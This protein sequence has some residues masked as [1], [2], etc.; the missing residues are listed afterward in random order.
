MDYLDTFLETLKME[1]NHSANTLEAYAG[2]L[3]RFHDFLELNKSHTFTNGQLSAGLMMDFL[4]AENR[5]GFSASTLQRRKMVVV[6]FAQFLVTIGI[7]TREQVEEVLAWRPQLWQEIYKQEILVLSEEEIDRLLIE[8]QPGG[9]VRSIRDQ[10]IISLLLETGLSIS[11]VIGLRLNDLDLDHETMTLTPGGQKRFVYPIPR[12]T[13]CLKRYI[14]EERPEVAQSKDEQSLFISQLGG[15]ISRQG[16]WQMLKNIGDRAEVPVPLSP[17][18]L[19]HTAVK[20]MIDAGMPT[21]E[22]QRRLGHTNVYSTRALVRKIKRAI[23]K[24]RSAE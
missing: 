15:P 9:P 24:N 1:K 3:R 12:S 4:E 20:R 8:N 5:S 7:F 11:D 14:Q 18:V 16:I 21:R 10:A 2:D 19:R 6:Q 22:I 13:E 23:N 17:R